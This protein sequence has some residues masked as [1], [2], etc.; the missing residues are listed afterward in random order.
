MLYLRTRYFQIA[1][2][3]TLFLN[4]AHQFKR[5]SEFKGFLLF[6][7]I[8]HIHIQ[9]NTQGIVTLLIIMSLIE[10]LLTLNRK[11]LVISNSILFTL[12]MGEKCDVR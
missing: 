5:F 10:L 3:H 4:L 1:L 9:E 12:V 6:L 11:D 7:H 2:L 8:S